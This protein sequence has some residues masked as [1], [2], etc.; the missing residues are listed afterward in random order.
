MSNIQKLISIILSDEKLKNRAAHSSII[1]QDEPILHTAS[2]MANDTPPKIREMRKLALSPDMYLYSYIRLFYLQ[3]K[4]M[5]D[6]EDNYVYQ[7]EFNRYYPTYHDMNNNQ[8]RGYFSW[9]TK[10]RHGVI[11]KTSLSFAYVYIYELLNQI[12]VPSAEA[13]LQMLKAF[14]STYQEFEPSIQTNLQTWI[15]DYVIYYDLDYSLLEKNNDTDFD[16]TLLILLHSDSHS[17]AEIF[18]A[19]CSLSTYRMEKSKFYQQNPEDVQ[20]VV[21]NIFSVLSE[22]YQKN[23]KNTFLEHLFGKKVSCPYEMFQSAVFYHHTSPR[24]GVYV[25]NEIHRYVCKN[26]IWTCEKYYSN[27]GKNKTLGTLLKAIDC[28]MREK[29]DFRYPL[30]QQKIPQYVLAILDKELDTILTSKKKHTTPPITIDLSK[31]QGIRNASAITR[32]KLLVEDEPEEPSPETPPIEKPAQTEN[33][34]G[35]HDT[36]LQFLQC[37]LQGNTYEALLREKGIMLSVLV[38]AINEKLFEQ[39]EDTIILL[40][41]DRPELIEDYTDKL[42]G[43]IPS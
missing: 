15:N 24:S 14:Q 7:G 43:M 4:F 30:K 37:L 13:G 18:E 23:R 26:N 42:K 3:G 2:Q 17:R 32:D 27:R 33:P 1:Y 36:E 16:N 40:E 6:Y 28:R 11:E 41:D 12:G 38:D 22:Y 10:V 21:C 34:Y 31:L 20:Q 25:I 19:L 8:L 35:L 9:R 29:Y 5:E 39:F